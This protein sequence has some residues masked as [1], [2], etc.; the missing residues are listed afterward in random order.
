MN[1]SL[2]DNFLTNLKQGIL[3]PL[4]DIIKIDSTLD[5][6]FRGN[7]LDV[8]YRGGVI[9]H[10]LEN[11]IKQNYSF[12]VNK[13]YFE[14]NKFNTIEEWIE[15]LPYIKQSR[16]FH[17]KK[18]N[19]AEREF[20]QL[21]TRTNNYERT[22]NSSDFFITDMEYANI[23]QID[24]V[25]LEWNSN[26]RQKSK[27]SSK[28]AFIEV[29]FGNS[30]VKG[31]SGLIDHLTD[32][33]NFVEKKYDYEN[34]V[35]DTLKI[36]QQKRELGL[37]ELGSNNNE[38]SIT[39]LE[40]NKP[41]FI[42]LLADYKTKGSNLKDLISSIDESLYKNLD[43]RFAISSF[44]GYGLYSECLFTKEQVIS[45]LNIKEGY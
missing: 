16:D 22:S 23:G 35:K 2:N 45:F 29:K 27:I 11:K 13:N 36:F 9:L 8:Y 19:T 14:E 1:R 26:F 4:L 37:F 32:I 41:Y 18:K 12:S 6:Q 25:A 31:D 17:Y 30:A 43:I 15:K 21:I 38:V 42:I 3:T 34:L 39:N 28:F 24:L 20:Q 5:L 10:V 7:S 40:Y 44:M 33:K